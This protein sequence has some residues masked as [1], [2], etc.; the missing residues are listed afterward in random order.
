MPYTV[1]LIRSKGVKTLDI[2]FATPLLAQLACTAYN[3]N[4]AHLD[5]GVEKPVAVY[6][7]VAND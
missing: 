6:R 3:L 2:K 1:E 4:L 7:E 5:D